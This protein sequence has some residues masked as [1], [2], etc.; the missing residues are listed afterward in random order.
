[1]LYE[2]LWLNPR[3]CPGMGG[4]QARHGLEH[5]AR[6]DAAPPEVAQDLLNKRRATSGGAASSR[7]AGG[8]M[9]GTHGTTP[10]APLVPLPAAQNTE[11][12]EE[13]DTE[14]FQEGSSRF[15]KRPEETFG[16]RFPGAKS[17]PTNAPSKTLRVSV[18]PFP[19][20]LGPQAPPRSF[21][22]LAKQTPPREAGALRGL[23]KSL[24]PT[25]FR[26]WGCGRGWCS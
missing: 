22:I 11:R 26:G 1:M 17:P 10:P 12:A 2:T 21:P 6:Q 9:L 13:G 19:P 14:I 8:E 24:W 7:A 25:S 23:A 20:C 4:F 15:R 3:D 16:R 18:P 5:V